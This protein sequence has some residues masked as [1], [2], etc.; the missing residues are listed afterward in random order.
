[1]RTFRIMLVDP[2]RERQP[3]EIPWEMIAPHA[4]QAQEN[5]DQTLERLNERGGLS[6][7]EACAVLE[8]RPWRRMDEPHSKTVSVG[9]L[10]QLIDA[11]NRECAENK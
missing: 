5:H 2:Y 9:R 4:A 6:P 1:M 7:C 10:E 11:F 8:D 3:R